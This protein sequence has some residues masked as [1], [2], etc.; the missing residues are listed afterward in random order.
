MIYAV[1]ETPPG[2]TIERTN[3]VAQQLLKIAE[4]E[5]GVEKCVFVGRFRNP[6]GGYKCQLGQLLDQ[7]EGLEAP[8]THGEADYRRLGKEVRTHHAS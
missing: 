3:E 4:K 8:K 5:E 6:L 7:S 1:I 2:A